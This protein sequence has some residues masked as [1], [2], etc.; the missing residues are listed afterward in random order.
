MDVQWVM[1]WLGL[2]ALVVILTSCN[3]PQRFDPERCASV[4]RQGEYHVET[5]L[6]VCELRLA[7]KTEK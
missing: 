7:G 5:A 4:A 1:F 6:W 3:G 2:L